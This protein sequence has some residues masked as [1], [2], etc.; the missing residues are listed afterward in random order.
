VL[1][2][3]PESDREKFLSQLEVIAEACRNI[4]NNKR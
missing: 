4:S 3:L 2:Q 1:E